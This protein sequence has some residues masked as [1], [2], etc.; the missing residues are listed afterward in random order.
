MPLLP[1]VAVFGLV[2]GVVA[3]QA[4]LSLV[5]TTTMSVL[6]FAGA[7]QFTA[8]S[9]WGQA[10]GL[11]IVATTLMINLRHLLMGASMAPHLRG[12]PAAWKA[13]LAFG[14]ADESY[15]LAISRYLRG[16]GSREFFLGANVALYAVWVLSS[17]TGGGLGGLV[18]NPARWGIDLV[19]PLTFLGLL[20][21][22]L[23]RPVTGA[24]AAT[25]GLV[26]VIAIAW[27]PG[28]G[29]LVL[30]VLLGSGIG[31]LLESRWTR[32]R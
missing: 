32:M 23:I 9:M 27:L 19:F 30:A 2:Y 31:T 29:N 12:Q 8:V 26:S 22:L 11:L 13:L 24:V 5:A 14:M 6:V 10:G 1:G 4:G 20:V 28:K 25:S 17:L 18:V 15:A 7:S 21:P 16:G 3:R